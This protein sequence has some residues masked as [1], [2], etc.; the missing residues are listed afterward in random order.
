MLS[1]S[2]LCHDP[3]VVPCLDVVQRT[4]KMAFGVLQTRVRL[5]VVRLQIGV[6]QLDQA[7][8]ILGCDRLVLLIKVV[9]VTVQDL[10]EELDGHGGVHAGIGNTQSALEA[11]ENTFAI[12]VELDTKSENVRHNQDMTYSFRVFLSLRILH[13]PPQMTGQVDGTTLVGLLQQLAT[14]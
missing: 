11:L 10:H 13:N 2:G 3:F 12:A 8:E 14:V 5:A 6:D 1:L 4:L 7:V 9:Y